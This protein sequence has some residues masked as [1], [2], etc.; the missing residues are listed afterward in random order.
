VGEKLFLLT[1][2]FALASLA[3]IPGPPPKAFGAETLAVALAGF[4]SS[5][6]AQARAFFTAD[7]PARGKK[8][9]RAVVALAAL[10]GLTVG[11]VTLVAGESAGL[12]WVAAGILVALASGVWNARILM[13]E[14]MR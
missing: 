13:I 12:Y 6:W 7:S 9:A 11:G 2:V 14:I 4:V 5:T 3:L 8:V 1:A 10:A